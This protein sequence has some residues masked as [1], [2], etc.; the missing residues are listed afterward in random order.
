MEQREFELGK[1][2]FGDGNAHLGVGVFPILGAPPGVFFPRF[3]LDVRLERRCDSIVQQAVQAFVDGTPRRGG[4]SCSACARA[5]GG[6]SRPERSGTK[7]VE[8]MQLSGDRDGIVESRN[9]LDQSERRGLC[10]RVG[11][12]RRQ[13]VGERGR[14]CELKLEQ[15]SPAGSSRLGGMSSPCSGSAVGSARCL[16]M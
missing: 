10:R 6:R 2:L 16:T 14:A 12:R 1:L 9:V 7:Q 15:W 3:A 13:R 5:G 8:E 4:R 11:Q